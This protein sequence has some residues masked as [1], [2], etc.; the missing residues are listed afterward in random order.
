MP[1]LLVADNNII[2]SITIFEDLTKISCGVGKGKF[3]RRRS[4]VRQSAI[5]C[6]IWHDRMTHSQQIYNLLKTF[7]VFRIAVLPLLPECV[8]FEVYISDSI[9]SLLLLSRRLFGSLNKMFWLAIG[10]RSS[11]ESFEF[12]YV[13]RRN[14]RLAGY[15]TNLYVT[16]N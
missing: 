10:Y 7:T 1:N 9:F 8:V 16:A 15:E 12:H 5:F 4:I 14:P 13:F 6:C 2:V 3:I 11:R